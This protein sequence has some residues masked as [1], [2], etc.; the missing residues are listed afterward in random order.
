MY[1][2]SISSIA[3]VVVVNIPLTNAFP[4]TSEAR[5]TKID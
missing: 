5:G 1:L 4:L 2:D 3:V